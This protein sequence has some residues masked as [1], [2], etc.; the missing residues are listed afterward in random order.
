MST[1]LIRKIFAVILV[2]LS[3]FLCWQNWGT[4]ESNAWMIA[5]AGWMIVLLDTE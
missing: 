5:F 4:S 2:L 1:K 3:S